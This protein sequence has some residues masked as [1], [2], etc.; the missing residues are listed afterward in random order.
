MNQNIKYLVESFIDIE[1]TIEDVDIEINRKTILQRHIEEVLNGET[2]LSK[3]LI[4]SEYNNGHKY[5]VSS[6]KEIQTII[7]R[8]KMDQ[9]NWIDTS[10]ITDMSELFKDNNGNN[11]NKM[12]KLSMSI[13]KASKSNTFV[14]SNLHF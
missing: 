5:I 8:I 10:K 6:K 12:S 11:S 3:K 7:N 2:R 14:N 9:Y 1:N 4:I 13:M